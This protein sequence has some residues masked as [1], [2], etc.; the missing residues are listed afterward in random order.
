MGMK[1]RPPTDNA[2]GGRV[3]QA[4]ETNV[5]ALPLFRK[6]PP[7]TCERYRPRPLVRL[8]VWTAIPGH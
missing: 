4:M 3:G 2:G 1:L 5:G 6:M 7:K 8:R